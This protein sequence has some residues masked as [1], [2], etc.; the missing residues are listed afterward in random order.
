LIDPAKARELLPPGKESYERP[1]DLEIADAPQVKTTNDALIHNTSRPSESAERQP[2]LPP[3]ATA[4]GKPRQRKSRFDKPLPQPEPRREPSPV[5][6]KGMIASQIHN[7]RVATPPPLTPEASLQSLD[8]GPPPSLPAHPGNA[9][10]SS[11]AGQRSGNRWSNDIRGTLE[12]PQEYPPAPPDPTSLS[13][14][15]SNDK[16]RVRQHPGGP[17]PISGRDEGEVEQQ[18]SFQNAHAELGGERE[19]EEQERLERPP[20]LRRGASLLDRLSTGNPR[21]HDSAAQQ[22]SLR[23]RLI[24]SKRDFED[25]ADEGMQHHDVSYDGED[26][27]ES[28]RARR[29]N[30][31][32]R[33][34]GGRR[35]GPA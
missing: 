8:N 9:L 28:K 21:S 13:Y 18:L 31:R 7:M 6:D 1:P 15:L 3:T 25:M 22:Q 14:R 34:R 2:A 29:K 4:P 32:A 23:D 11:R 24:P 27:A 5:S 17:P 26:G 10:A 16:S 33:I 12:Q 19:P 35:G 30:G 20:V